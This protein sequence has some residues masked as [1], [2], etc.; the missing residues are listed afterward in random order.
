MTQEIHGKPT[1]IYLAPGLPPVIRKKVLGHEN[2]HAL[3]FNVG[4]IPTYGLKGELTPLFSRLAT[5]RQR[6][7]LI[8]SES[9]VRLPVDARREEIAEAIRTYMTDPNGFKAVAPKTAKRIREYVNS[10]PVWSKII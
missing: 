2:G 5:G 7:P 8:L 6:R 4:P 1:P 3:D 9:F 10:D